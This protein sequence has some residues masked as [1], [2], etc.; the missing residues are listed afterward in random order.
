MTADKVKES[1]KKA[2]ELIDRKVE[3]SKLPGT[4]EFAALREINRNIAHNNLK[5]QRA[6]RA[7]GLKGSSVRQGTKHPIKS[8]S[9]FKHEDF[10]YT[11]GKGM[12]GLWYAEN[13]LKKVL[14]PYYV[15]VRDHNPGCRVYLVQDNVSLHGLG[16]RYCALEIE[17]L[18]ILFAPH[19]P[20]SPDLHPIERCFG[21]LE[22]FLGDYEVHS[23]SK[24][25][26][27]QA[28]DYVKY[29]WQEDESM[30]QYMAEQLH[31]TS[32]KSNAER[33]QDVNCNNNYTA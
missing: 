21:R 6:N 25:A 8:E 26:R 12:S 1:N 3:R 13:I 9:R 7:K 4:H 14:F 11:T 27:K 10:V 20:N 19:P 5:V 23:A 24:E 15:A 33:C 22:G 29:V 28:E 30:R 16:L 2:K 18:S 31:P 17:E 32:F